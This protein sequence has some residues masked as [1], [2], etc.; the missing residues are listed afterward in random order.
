MVILIITIFF[1]S[2]LLLLPNPSSENPSATIPAR[3]SYTSHS[4]I[5][6]NGNANFATKATAESWPGDGSSGNP[7]VIAGYDI[8][9]SS[10]KGIE[11][12]N[13]N[14]H[15]NINDCY[16]HN[17]G[18]SYS[19]ISLYNCANGTISNNN[20]SDNRFGIYLYTS[21]NNIVSSNTCS[22]NTYYGIYLGLSSNNIVSSNNCSSNDDCGIYLSSSS[23]N[24]LINNTCSNNA[25]YGIFLGGSSNNTLSNNN[26][27]NNYYG[28]YSTSSD[29]TISNNT[30][31]NNNHDGIDIYWP[32]NNNTLSNNTCSSNDDCGIYLSS[33]SNTLSNNTCSNNWNGIYL[34]SSSNNT[35]S[36][37]S[38]SSNDA[39]GIYLHSSRDDTI[40]TNTCSSNSWH[41]IKLYS[42]SNNTISNNSCSSNYAYGIQLD[43]SSSNTLSNNNCSNNDYGIFLDLSSSSVISWNKLCNNY[44]SGVDVYSGSYNRI[45]INTFIGNNLGG[46]QANDDGTNNHWNTSGSPHGYGNYWS[47]LTTPD[48]NFDGIVDWSYNLTG[49]TEAKDFYPLTAPPGSPDILPPNTTSSPSGTIGENGW[50]RS[51]VVLTL[52]AIDSGTVINRAGVNATFFRIGTSGSWLKYSSSFVLSNDGISTVQFYSTDNGSNIESKKSTAIKIDTKSPTTHATITGSS[53][54][55]SA[56]DNVSEVN[57]TKYRVDSGTWLNYSGAFQVAA[58]GNHTIEFYSIDNAGNNESMKT[59]WVSNG[60]DGGLG[61]IFNQYGIPI[62]GFI[63]A[64]I[65]VIAVYHA[66]S[67]KGKENE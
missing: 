59:T 2:S 57:C 41:G 5:F 6:I 9:A 49:A 12:Y 16:V 26:C 4:T 24:T 64:I 52:S 17:G 43:L 50:Y 30:C 33:S 39:Y 27:S 67:S 10:A 40:S 21:S 46:I 23:D 44:H 36:N 45:W 34:W 19:G 60:G 42:S 61:S 47:D 8:D 65:V 51:S 35:I 22:N 56:S 63:I 14:V 62:I 48:V 37:N 7:Y 54:T 1:A 11:I 20:C 28:I 31:S 32:G 29:N 55:L 53:V 25:Y 58:A 15:F 13:T 3:I 38:C 66:L 18:S